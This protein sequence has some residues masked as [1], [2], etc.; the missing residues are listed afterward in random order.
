VRDLL[1]GGALGIF[2]GTN[3]GHCTWH[4]FAREIARA[5]GDDPDRIAPCRSEEYPT[6]ARRPRCSILRSRRLEEAGV[7]PRPPW[8]DALRRYLRLLDDQDR[9]DR[10]ER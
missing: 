3:A 6:P 10:K 4:E 9:D 8:Q 1:R 7:Q 2:H 5:G